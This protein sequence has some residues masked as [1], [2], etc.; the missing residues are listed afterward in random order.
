MSFKTVDINADVGEGLGNEALL[1]PY[2]SSCNIACGGHAGDAKTM[3]EVVRLAKNHK[4]KIGAHPSFPDVLNFGRAVMDISAADL[5]SS[6]K[7][8]IRSLQQILH[9]ENAQLHHIK[10]HGALY[11]LAAKDEKT[12]RIIIEVVKSIAMPIQLYVPYNSVI[13][14]L[15]EQEKISV[16]FEAFA[17]RNYEENLSL[18]SRKK[19]DA[20]LHKNSRILNHILGMIHREKITSINGVEV[21]IKASTF[22]VHGDTKNAVEILE[23]LSKELPKYN[24]KIQ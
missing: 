23:F 21:P 16:T 22:C 15:A 24:V 6:L 10:P 1:I 14:K 20:I 13:S 19:E 3:T 17:D 5:Y 18:V 11:N 12:A 8:Q 2:L 7:S 4:V 9:S